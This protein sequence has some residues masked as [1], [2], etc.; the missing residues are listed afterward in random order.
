MS[1]GCDF[2]N[3]TA[4]EMHFWDCGD[5]Y[6]NVYSATPLDADGNYAY[7]AYLYKRTLVDLDIDNQDT[8][9]TVSDDLSLDIRVF[10]YSGWGACKWTE[11]P[12]FGLLANQPACTHG[13]PCPIKKG[14]QK[15]QIYINFED[16]TQITRILKNDAP[17]QL[18]FVVTNKATNRKACVMFQAR[19]YTKP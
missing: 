14:P 9:F 15:I 11:I 18:E 13:V 8:E 10:Q 7:P 4:T 5:G 1:F 19:A 6:V 16:F 2:P 3:G 12:T 17:Y